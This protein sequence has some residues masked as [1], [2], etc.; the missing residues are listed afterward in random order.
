M[1]DSKISIAKTLV[2]EGG[3]VNNPNDSGGATKYGITQADIPNVNIADITPEQATEYYIEHYW[4]N[5]YSE[6]DTQVVADKLFDMG[7]LFGVGTA[8]KLLQVVLSIIPQD[9]VFGPH[10]LSATNLAEPNSLLN[11]YHAALVS[12]AVGIADAQPKD[13][14]FLVGWIR[15][16][17]S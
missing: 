3:Y 9:G 8:V 14:V 5:L 11:S 1:A 7:V 13:R 16:I 10:T 2:H 12:H 15:R 4:K 6:I 17:N